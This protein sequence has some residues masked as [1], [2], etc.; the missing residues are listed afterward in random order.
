MKVIVGCDADGILTDLSHHNIREGSR[1]YKREPVHPEQYS[2]EEI[3][4]LDDVPK[5]SLYLNA[6][7]IYINY[8]K[9]EPPRSGVS[10]TFEAL[11]LKGFVFH[12]ITA[13]KF[14]AGNTILGRL[15]RKWFR[16]WLK[17]YHINFSS[18]HFC[19]EERS[20]QDKLLACKKL[21]VDA[22]I[23]DKPEVAL[24]LASNGIK[25]I[26]IDA[27]YNQD[28]FHENI[29]HVA[30]WHQVRSLLE[31]IGRT[32][33]ASEESVFVKRSK[34]ELNLLS[35][36]KKIEYFAS[37]SSYLKSMYIDET[38][39]EKG[40]RR[41]KILYSCMKL[42]AKAFYHVTVVGREKIPYQNGF[43]IA[44][45]HSDSTDQYRLGLAIGNRPF[46]GY[47]A[48]E[49]ADTFR[50]RLFKA[51]GLGIFIDRN[52]SE[53]KVRSA[54]LLAAYVAHDRI[55]LLFPEGTRKNKTEEG[56]KKFQNKFK[57]GTVALAQKTGTGILPVATNAFGRATLV[58]FGEMIFVNP[59][60]DL[61]E[62]NRK[63]EY[64]IARL[65]YENIA[66]YLKKKNRLSE[67]DEET[68]K[69]HRYLL[70]VDL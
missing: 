57:L 45:N 53:D 44:S 40:D 24:H 29:I 65:S 48:K 55:A 19:S 8:C 23:E 12:S 5:L 54:E 63:L 13:R 41:F 26:M 11:S 69:F 32:K 50:G 25:V 2:L 59:T 52:D 49:I 27:P 43:I 31:Q 46:V 34:E 10:E 4:D 28:T 9:N 47:A 62:V 16:Q 3:F 56:R 42:P 14:A 17:K 38:A 51:T 22:M 18:F 37:Y 35:D 64:E 70:E 30:D 60:D 66:D 61:E 36:A 15:A 6:F 20:P 67:L 7:R 33:E 68:E 21:H 58:R 1:I 39:L